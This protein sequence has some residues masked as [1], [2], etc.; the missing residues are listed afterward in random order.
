M[1]RRFPVTNREYLA[2]LDD[3]VAQGREEEA[4]L[5]V[6]RERVGTQGQEGPMNY[7][8]DE[9][10]RF[11]LVVDADGDAW[12]PD[13]P[14]LNIHFGCAVAFGRWEAARRGRP[15][16]LPGDLEWEKAA[17]GV[18]GRF[19]PW[20][21]VLD[22]AWCC[23]VDSYAGRPLPAVVDSFP[24]DESTFGVRGMGG[25][26]QDWCADLHRRDGP[27]C[28]RVA[29]SLRPSETWTCLRPLG[30]RGAAA[31]GSV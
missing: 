6:P 10:G 1:M 18:D 30:A 9:R 15:W 7:G 21:D 2:F 28:L 4:L 25:N 14:V 20:G 8:R 26:V 12:L 24:V 27:A 19:F 5:W 13:W 29:W 17:R 3:L 23:W 16:R 31:P 22:G 11:A